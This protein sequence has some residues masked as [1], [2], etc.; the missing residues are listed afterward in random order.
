MLNRRLIRIKTFKA[1]YAYIYSGD[2]SRE[3]A[4]NNLLKSC[5][6][7]LELYYFM[8]N[9]AIAVTDL[10]RSRIEAGVP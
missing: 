7:T 3:G 10:A 2:D 8:L 5:D 9:L 1:L 4:V 6:M